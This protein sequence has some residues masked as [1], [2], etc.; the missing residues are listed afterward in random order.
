MTLSATKLRADLYR[1]LDEVARTGRAVSVKRHGA[2]LNIVRAPRGKRSK[3]RTVKLVDRPGVVV[4]DPE[5]LVHIDWSK[6]WKP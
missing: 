6:Y 4:G 5:S 2:T 3:R 1:I